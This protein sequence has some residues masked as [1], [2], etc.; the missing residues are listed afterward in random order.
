FVIILFGEILPKNVAIRASSL[1]A[2][3]VAYPLSF[4]AIIS[5][6]VRA[7]L[8]FVS[9]RIISLFGGKI[10]TSRRMI[11]EEEFRA[12]VAMGNQAEG[13]DPLEK[14]LVENVFEFSAKT[15]RDFITPREKMVCVS[16]EATLPEIL[17]LLRKRRYS[18]IPVYRKQKTN[19]V[20]VLYAK[21]L[22]GKKNESFHLGDYL[23][24]PFFVSADRS[25]S[26]LLKDF[27]SQKIHMAFVR[28]E[29]NV[30]GLVTLDD[31]LRKLLEI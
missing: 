25:V 21:E 18:R 28:E 2:P 8:L 1:F 23:N 5:W 9:D 10:K 20:G 12:L 31:L 13:V 27:Q 24:P 7:I 16:D 19:I 17:G 11:V 6:P 29:E 22:L 3:L 26:N 4:F 30:L 15:V 14:K